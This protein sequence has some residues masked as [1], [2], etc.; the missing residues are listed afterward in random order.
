MSSDDYYLTK[1]LDTSI[2]SLPSI[3]SERPSRALISISPY[4][5]SPKILNKNKNLCGIEK[6][7]CENREFVRKSINTNFK[8]PF[9]GNSS[10]LSPQHE[11]VIELN[12][13]ST[14][15]SIVKT[16]KPSSTYV[17]KKAVKGIL[18]SAKHN[19]KNGYG[20]FLKSELSISTNKIQNKQFAKNQS[21]IEPSSFVLLKNRQNVT[22]NSYT[23][24]NDQPIN[25]NQKQSSKLPTNKE[26]TEAVETSLG[27]KLSLNQMSK[28]F[29]NSHDVKKP[30]Q[31]KPDQD[32]LVSE[33][34]IN[35]TNGKM[36]VCKI[37]TEKETKQIQQTAKSIITKLSFSCQTSESTPNYEQNICQASMAQKRKPQTIDSGLFSNETDQEKKKKKKY[38]TFQPDE[39]H[40]LQT[41]SLV[42]ESNENF[43][44]TQSESFSEVDFRKKSREV[45]VKLDLNETIYYSPC[46]EKLMKSKEICLF[47]QNEINQIQSKDTSFSSCFSYS[48]PLK[49]QQDN[50]DQDNLQECK[51]IKKNSFPLHNIEERI[52]DKITETFTFEE[53]NNSLDKLF[54]P[55]QNRLDKS[56]NQVVNEQNNYNNLPCPPLCKDIE[57]ESAYLV[58]NE[59]D[60][61]EQNFKNPIYLKEINKSEGKPLKLGIPVTVQN[62]KREK[63]NL[64]NEVFNKREIANETDK[65]ESVIVNPGFSNCRSTYSLKSSKKEYNIPL[66]QSAEE[67][68]SKT[69]ENPKCLPHNKNYLSFQSLTSVPNSNGDY[70]PIGLQKTV[71]T[72]EDNNPIKI[73]ESE[74][75]SGT[76]STSYQTNINHL[77]IPKLNF[78][79]KE[80]EAKIKI[81]QE[82]SDELKNMQNKYKF[83]LTNENCLPVIEEVSSMQVLGN[84][85]FNYEESLHLEP[86]P[87]SISIYSDYF[88]TEPDPSFSKILSESLDNLSHRSLGDINSQPNSDSR[89]L[90]PFSITMASHAYTKTS[91]WNNNNHFEKSS[92]KHNKVSKDLQPNNLKLNLS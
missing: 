15:L 79:E 34:I 82:V 29:L 42:D 91:A 7:A 48:S 24:Q 25:L 69:S 64:I 28:T 54:S 50:K 35:K 16:K 20:S 62:L 37:N 41:E 49:D 85:T 51:I 13:Y 14:P 68:L 12:D 55:C 65:R 32:T 6:I 84:S 66:I 10:I 18:P 89:S 63:K 77:N 73:E 44:F 59:S 11:Y 30:F 92:L 39:I 87:R 58:E 57:T 8:S 38:I 56:N 70:V 4:T 61:N 90:L 81:D 80:S 76:S 75:P 17:S 72:L 88:L 43:N 9:L 33:E 22:S 78:A 74:R 40:E 52:F 5:L 60:S 3:L 19:D 31:N 47:H 71:K 23:L 2:D 45:Q 53:K 67:N 26:V 86:N 1:D 27:N 83:S 46:S 21:G 36:R